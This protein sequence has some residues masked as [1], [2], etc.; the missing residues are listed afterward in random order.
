MAWPE[1]F[2]DDAFIAFHHNIWNAQGEVVFLIF[3]VP[4]ATNGHHPKGSG[5]TFSDSV[6]N[7]AHS[8]ARIAKCRCD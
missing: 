2:A 7:F 5:H 3:W 1:R 4:M 8:C 6:K